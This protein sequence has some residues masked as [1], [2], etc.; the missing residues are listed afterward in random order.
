MGRRRKILGILAMFTF[1]FVLAIVVVDL[2][3]G[4]K[5]AASNTNTFSG[6]L[7]DNA[8]NPLPNVKL[9]LNANDGNNGS[10]TTDNSGNFA[11]PVAPDA[12]ALSVFCNNY[13]T[14]IGNYLNGCNLPGTQTA[15]DLTSGNV[16]Q[17]L[18]LDTATLIVNV[19]YSNGAPVSGAKVYAFGAGGVSGKIYLFSGDAGEYIASVESGDTDAING[20]SA[21][22]DTYGQINLTTINGTIYGTGLYNNTGTGICAIVSGEQVC[23]TTS[24][25]VNGAASVTITAPATHT[26]SGTLTDSA[27]NPLP[28]V[29]VGIGAS[30]GNGS[31]VM[32]DSDGNFTMSSVPDNYTLSVQ[33]FNFP[34]VIDHYL[35]TC[36]LSGLQPSIDLTDG[37]ITKNL[38]LSTTNL[39]ATIEYADGTPVVN[40]KVY[41]EGGQA[42]ANRT[43]VHL[44]PGDP[45]NYL[46]TGSGDTAALNG[47]SAYTDTSGRVTLT[48]IVGSYYGTDYNSATGL[49]A[50]ISGS[51][52]CI[53]K[54]IVIT[55][56]TNVLIQQPTAA[57]TNLTATTPTNHYPVL[58]W[59]SVA[60][61]TYY[62]VYR[63]G[64]LIDTIS[65]SNTS[66]ID[67]GAPEGTES[68][69]V[70]AL[71]DSAES[72]SSNTVSVTYDVTPPSLGD[73]SWSNNPV[74]V[75]SDTTLTVPVSDAASGV[76]AGEYYVGS[77]DP[78]QGNGT[79][80]VYNAASG[81]LTVT[82]GSNLPLG[83]YTFNIRAQDNAG[84]WSNVLSSALTVS[85]VAPTNLTATTPTNQHPSLTWNGTDDAVSYNI[86]RGNVDIGSTTD[87]SYVD[88]SV[89][90]GSYNYYVT[91]VDA[92]GSESTPSN[93]ITVVYDTAGPTITITA[94]TVSVV[95]QGM[96]ATVGGTATDN[97]SGIQNGKVVV[98]LRAILPDGKLGGFLNTLTVS[99]NP[100]RH[101]WSAT[102][103]STAFP[104][105][106]YGVTVLANDNA[107][108]SQTAVGGASLKPFTIDNTKPTVSFTTPTS[109]AGPFTAG[110]VVTITASDGVGSGLMVMAI[111]VYDSSNQLLT[112]CGSATPAQVAAGSMSCDTS[113]LA[114]GTYYIKAGATDGAGHNQT[115]LSGNFTVNGT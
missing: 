51:Q 62:S 72:T 86:Y 73:P 21:Y 84:N 109:F 25:T 15:I 77:T 56:E 20:G 60:N 8:G 32:T 95:V 55:G 10:T 35:N 41:A 85:T 69:Y 34:T 93:T 29:K 101:V 44:F 40:A 94:P 63:N 47:G 49:C 106:Q 112:T 42:I 5:A 13:P 79:P 71:N 108:N 45:G 1:V 64:Q 70:T 114:P 97:L 103:D 6:T 9:T 18:R 2:R 50:T 68:Y 7:T 111:H 30:D 82:A 33:C 104:D 23:T 89:T 75:G 98:H 91:A 26:F 48:T 102:F 105:G 66:Y 87:T 88:G 58:S 83:T 36:S 31:S 22:T 11:I 74:A 38:Q 19:K 81:T 12:Y 53:Q 76:Y 37:D 67:Y 100:L 14:V 115:V 59:D 61:A 110:P 78:G 99:V 57:P 80:M 92:G 28:N 96:N 90:Q 46:E 3:L 113:S 43:D 17:N 65:S 24:I 27:G 54:P 52:V 4:A 39:N 16:T 107:G